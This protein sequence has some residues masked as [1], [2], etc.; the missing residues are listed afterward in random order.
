MKRAELEV[1][2][3]HFRKD[4]S[5]CGL[6]FFVCFRKLDEC[7]TINYG[8]KFGF[9]ALKVAKCLAPQQMQMNHQKEPAQP[10]ALHQG[11]CH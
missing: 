5:S 2:L 6:V 1:L 10:L 9:L 8:L 3:F 11:N 7:D 4:Y